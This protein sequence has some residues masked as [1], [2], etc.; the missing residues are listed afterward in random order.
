[1]KRWRRLY[2]FRHGQTDWNRDGRIQGHL[3]VPLN[4]RGREQARALIPHLRRLGVQAF[5]S[6]DLSRARETAEIAARGLGVEVSTDR[7]L[8][9]I[10]LGQAQGLTR[11]EIASRFGVEFSERLRHT[12]LSDADVV[13]LGSESGDEVVRRAHDSIQA[14]LLGRDGLER[15]AVVTHG[16]VLRRLI[17]Y[18]LREPG[19]PAPIP[20]GALYPLL[21]DPETGG[22]IFESSIPWVGDDTGVPTSQG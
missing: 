15:V 18:A 4:D 16:G 20:N 3:D 10:F 2:A 11:E 22:W 13:Q 21:F 7:G 17:Q 19:F 1:M 9:E 6:S 8:R 5:L 14:F 12:P